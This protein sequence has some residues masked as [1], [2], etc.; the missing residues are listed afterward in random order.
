MK[1]RVFLLIFLLSASAAWACNI[2]VFR[3]ALERWRPD[4][5]Q[6]ILFHDG[7]LLG[8]A[9]PQLKQLQSQLAA[10][11][12]VA[13]AELKLCDLLST[14]D[15]EL[16]ELWKRL[17]SS[18][19]KLTKPHVLMRVNQSRGVVNG[20]HGSLQDTVGGVLNSPV[21]SEVVRR[22]LSGHAIV[23]IVMKSDNEA[24]NQEVQKMLATRFAS[25][26]KEIN[27]PE[28]IGLPGSEL[29]SEVPLL[30]KFSSLE[31]D[32]KDPREQFLVQLFS[33]FRPDE[34]QAGQPLVIPV[35][36]RGRALEVVPGSQMSSELVDELT[37]FLCGAC[38]CQVKEN[39]PG[40][41]LLLSAAWD[42]EL[43]G[44]GGL[45]PPPPKTGGG[46]NAAAP[47]RILQVP[48]G[49]KK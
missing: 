9:E 10:N 44:E 26:E 36:G 18:T 47:P 45:L 49:R 12:G 5:I 21:R 28:G 20:W 41:D 4:A 13:N 3:Y 24:R 35:F 40:F 42:K 43:F 29:Y 32:P 15:D 16:K 39:N 33:G 14:D 38:S 2:P 48:P 19:D 8:D 37:Q 17:S 11:G 31:L 34:I 7:P 1:T 23:W 30:L 22:L 6:L 27:L 46:D 25:L